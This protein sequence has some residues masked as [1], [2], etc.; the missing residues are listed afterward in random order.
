MSEA[1]VPHKL[2]VRVDRACEMLDCSRQRLYDLMNADE[3]VSYLDGGV[4]KILVESIHAYIAKKVA[5]DREHAVHPETVGQSVVR[6][7]FGKKTK[8]AQ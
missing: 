1:S 4:R 2:V 8:P 3:I 7:N 5:E 6:R